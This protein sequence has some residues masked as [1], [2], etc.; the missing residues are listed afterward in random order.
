[1][2]KVYK[3]PVELADDK[4]LFEEQA[5]NDPYSN[6][7][8]DTKKYDELVDSWLNGYDPELLQEGTIS[9]FADDYISNANEGNLYENTPQGYKVS[10][11]HEAYIRN[12][13]E[14]LINSKYDYLKPF[15]KRNA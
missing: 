15:Y 1:M 8:T 11:D 2:A 5:A 9:D 13:V 14:E 12:K 10:P 3:T 6:P 7:P 4:A